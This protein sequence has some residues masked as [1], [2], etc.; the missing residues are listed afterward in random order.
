MGAIDKQVVLQDVCGLING[1][2]ISEEEIIKGKFEK[3][4][5]SDETS[6]QEPAIAARNAVVS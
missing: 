3:I 5:S 6:I 1:L 2:D 4:L